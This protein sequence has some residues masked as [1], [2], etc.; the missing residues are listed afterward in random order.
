MQPEDRDH[1]HL[2]DMLSGAQEVGQIL[3]DASL[4]EFESNLTMMRAIERCIEIVG[5]AARRVSPAT[6]A[7]HTQIPWSDIIG[8]RNILAHEYGQIDYE[9][10]YKTASHDVPQLVSILQD[11][12]PDS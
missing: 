8:Q 2:W 11:L 10:L 1:A 5:E 3:A 7:I 6:R 12:L 9:L 4:D